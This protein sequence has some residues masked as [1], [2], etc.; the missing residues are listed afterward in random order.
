MVI[1]RKMGKIDQRLDELHKIWHVEYRCYV[2]QCGLVDYSLYCLGAI[3]LQMIVCTVI[4][5]C[6][7]SGSLFFT[8]LR[9]NN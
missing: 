4:H 5:N 1:Q 6:S 8:T 9:Q 7:S 2:R 3:I